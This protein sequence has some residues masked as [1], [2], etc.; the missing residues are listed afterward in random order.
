MKLIQNS[1]LYTNFPNCFILKFKTVFESIRPGLHSFKEKKAL[2]GYSELL[3]E[4]ISLWNEM[5]VFGPFPA[6]MLQNT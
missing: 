3:S 4:I 6:E 1:R 2:L 5:S